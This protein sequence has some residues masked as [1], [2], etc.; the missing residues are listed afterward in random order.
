MYVKCLFASGEKFPECSVVSILLF[1]QSYYFF[2]RLMKLCKCGEKSQ[3]KS[4]PQVHRKLVPV[5]I[6]PQTK[7]GIINFLNEP[8]K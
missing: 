3:L 6:I 5:L 7:C 8:Q 2:R 1:I 4:K